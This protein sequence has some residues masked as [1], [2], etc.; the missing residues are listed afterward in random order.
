[1]NEQFNHHELKLIYESVRKQQTQSIAKCDLK[2]YSELSTILTK[3][4]PLAYQ[5]TYI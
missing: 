2:L 4:Q 5:E 1:M 3:L